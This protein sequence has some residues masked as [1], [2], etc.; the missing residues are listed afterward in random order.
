MLCCTT[1]LCL[2][3][4]PSALPFVRDEDCISSKI[5]MCIVY[6]YSVNI[7]KDVIVKQSRKKAL[8]A[9]FHV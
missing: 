4:V 7:T 9:H 8:H 5:L 2:A 3:A 1:E 6:V